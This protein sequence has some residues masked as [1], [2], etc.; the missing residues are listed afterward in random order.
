MR[1]EITY[2][3]PRGSRKIPLIASQATNWVG[4]RQMARLD[5]ALDM[6]DLD[7]KIEAAKGMVVA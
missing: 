2:D 1:I 4:L 3:T 5:G 7:R 6:A